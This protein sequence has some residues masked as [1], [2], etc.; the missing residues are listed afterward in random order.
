[1]HPEAYTWWSRKAREIGRVRRVIEIGSRD[2]NGS[3]RALFAC[4]EY[5]GIDIAPGPGVDLVADG[6]T[7]RPELPADLVVC[8]EVLE[9]TPVA[10]LVVLNAA[11]ML[12]PG[13]RFLLTCAAPGRAPHSGVDG[14]ALRPDEFYRNVDED[15]LA[16]WLD[17]AGF[18]GRETVYH[19]GRGDLYAA[20]LK[21]AA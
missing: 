16:R 6:A 18:V 8:A 3:I 5:V 1:M 20:A 11:A 12:V 13:G 17:M 10:P 4:R 21:G 2:I 15:A 9:H 14:A 7:W 19:P